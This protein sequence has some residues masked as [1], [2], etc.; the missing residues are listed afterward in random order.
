M[1]DSPVRVGDV[2][3]DKYAVERVLGRGG[4]GVVVAAR[5]QLLEQ[6]VAIKFLLPDA[7]ENPAVVQRFGREAQAAARI[8]SEHVARVYDVGKLDSGVPYIV[9]E[10]LEGQDLA[11]RVREHGAMPVE[12]VVDLVLQ[13][14]EALAEAHQIGIIHRDLKPANLFL[15]QRADG[16]PCVKVLDFGISKLTGSTTKSRLTAAQESVGSPWYMSPEQLHSVP[17]IDARADIWSLGVIIYE[18]LCSHVPFDGDSLPVVCTAILTRPTPRMGRPDVPPG[19]QQV[20]DTCLRKDRDERFSSLLELAGALAPFGSDAA[21]S[22]LT[23]IRGIV[24]SSRAPSHPAATLG[25]GATTPM[26][27]P[28]AARVSPAAGTLVAFGRTAFKSSRLRLPK[29][30]LALGA[31][32]LA[33]VVAVAAVLRDPA[34]DATNPAGS[35]LAS[36]QSSTGETEAIDQ[37]VDSEDDSRA[38]RNPAP[39]TDEV[40][41]ANAD[42]N[43]ADHADE[44]TA[45]N[46]ADHTDERHR[47]TDEQRAASNGRVA[48]KSIDDLPR[49]A[50]PPSP[51]A[52]RASRTAVRA[53]PKQGNSSPPRNTRLT[54]SADEVLNP[55][56]NRAKLQP[57]K[58]ARDKRGVY[59]IRE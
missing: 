6:R 1:E 8:K 36:S 9:L 2:I 53:A 37:V 22:S 41:E 12:Q 57:K 55:W 49:V 44:N 31:L 50:E 32:S 42:E 5:H 18:L 59:D 4:M 29:S 34:D 52:P 33:A 21:R 15:T 56:K 3:A 58:G 39:N 28:P 46:T 19:L 13:A 48:T 43:T 20:V 54:S 11:Q 7:M 45:Q 26:S 25:K 16:H 17:T 24:T 40:D 10:Y 30:A 23:T 27:V 35:A 14:C 47:P 38:H 51:K